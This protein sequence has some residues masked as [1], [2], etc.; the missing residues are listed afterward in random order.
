MDVG[1]L[2]IVCIP[3]PKDTEPAPEIAQWLCVSGD[4]DDL[5]YYDQEARHSER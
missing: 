5:I 3:T 1:N 2:H 4:I